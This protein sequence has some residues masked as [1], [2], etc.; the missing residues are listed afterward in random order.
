MC[1][2][3]FGNE[4]CNGAISIRQ[5]GFINDCYKVKPQLPMGKILVMAMG[6]VDHL[7]LIVSSIY[8]ERCEDIIGSHKVWYLITL[9]NNRHDELLIW[10]SNHKTI[11][12]NVKLYDVYKIIIWSKTSKDHLLNSKQLF[13]F[14]HQRSD[15][16]I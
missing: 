8:C 6:F 14:V 10:L 12:F 13:F 5:W 16:F 3:H 1:Y 4:V 7:G 15:I 9:L 11:K 2:S